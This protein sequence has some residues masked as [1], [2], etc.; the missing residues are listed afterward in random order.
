[1][2]ADTSGPLAAQYR[3]LCDTVRDYPGLLPAAEALQREL[4]RT[5]RRWYAIIE[6]LRSF[7]LKNFLLHDAHSQ[8]MEAMQTVTD[9]LFEAVEW[10]DLNVS[11]KGIDALMFYL[12]KILLDGSRSLNDYW[13]LLTSAFA[14][15]VQLDSDRFLSAVTNAHPLKR[16][17]QRILD[18]QPEGCSVDVLNSLLD[19]SFRE[20]YA[21]WLNETDPVL[22]FDNAEAFR[23]HLAALKKL[24]QPV[25]HENL[26]ALLRHLDTL[27]PDSDDISRLNALLSLP[28]H[29]QIV[30]F[31]EEHADRLPSESDGALKIAYL[32]KM[33]ESD[34]LEGIH[35]ET[36]REIGRTVSSI[37]KA[38]TPETLK[39]ALATPLEILRKNFRAFPEA[40]LHCVQSIGTGVYALGNSALV[41]WFN[42]CIIAFGFQQPE[43]SGITDDWQVS[44]NKS[45]VRNIR[46]WLELIEQSPKWSKSLLAALLIN[47]RLGGVHINDTDL[48]QKDITRLLNS[49]IAPAY[50][51][52]KQLAKGFPAY[53]NVINAEGALREVSTALDDAT[54]TRDPLV[55][56]LRK[57]CH[58]E[59][60]SIMVDFI[61][62]ALEFWRTKDKNGLRAY[63]PEEVFR[64][65]DSDGRYVTDLHRLMTELFTALQINSVSDLLLADEYAIQ[66]CIDRTSAPDRERSRAAL[67]VKFYRLLWQKYRLG[68]HD[69]REQLAASAG[70]GL[71]AC[72]ELIASLESESIQIRLAAALHHLDK[73][74]AIILSSERFEAIED[75]ARKRHVAAGI[76]SMYG[77]YI[78]KK[79]NAL[80]LT[81]RLENYANTLFEELMRTFPLR[82]VTRATLFQIEKYTKL[83]FHALK[84]DGISSHRLENTLELLSGALEVRRFSYSQFIDIFR[85][86]SEGVQDILSTY[87]TGALKAHLRAVILQLGNERIVPKYRDSGDKN[88]HDFVN[89]VSEKLLRDM[90]ALSPGLQQLD[91]FISSILRTLREQAEVLDEQKLDLLMSYDPKKIVSAIHSPARATRDRIH[92][93]N[94][95]YNLVKLSSLGIPVPPGFL[96]TT[97]VFRCM[98]AIHQFGYAKEHL[99]EEIARQLKR[100]EELTGRKLGDPQRPLLVSARSGAALSMPGMMNS[101]LNVGLN[102]AIVNGLVDMTGK[103]WFAWDCYRRFLQCWGMFFGMERDVFDTIIDTFKRRH[104]VEMKLQFTPEQMRGIALAYRDTIVQSGIAISDDPFVQLETAI[105]QVFQSWDSQKARAYRQIL[106]ISEQWGTAVLVQAMAYGNLDT[107][108]GT[109]VLFTR[110]PRELSD[111]VMLWGDFAIGAQGEDIVSG[112]VKTLPISIEQKHFEERT[113]DISLEEL[114]PEIYAA[115]QKIVKNL[116]YTEQWSAQEIEFTFEGKSAEQLAILQTRDMTVMRHESVSAFIPTQELS[117]AFCA[118][119]IGVGGG[120]LSGRAVFDLHDIQTYRKDDPLTPLILIRADTVPDD[121][122]LISATDGLLTARGGSTSHAAIIAK[123]LGKTCVVGC[124]RLSVFE[125]DKACS[126]HK[127]TVRAGDFLSIDGRGGAI[128]LGSHPSQVVRLAAE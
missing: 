106:G 55:H 16:L 85:G 64:S 116:I 88:E 123:R 112:L 98:S 21:F 115:L 114:F 7:A 13:P 87:Y 77:R 58:V 90:V 33:L 103:P 93:G 99:M 83:F 110:N 8:G 105:M 92:L 117:S 48:F 27:E 45:H 24:M 119:G 91:A 42:Q 108:S 18:R 56:F 47:L 22:W 28:G 67:I 71:P 57:H 17:A 128:Y 2:A 40:T 66:D 121:I 5:P 69:L 79:F 41:E 43:V 70:M 32:L 25:S 73:L 9:I 39:H 120:A 19:R 96:I 62:A 12:Q 122:Q 4:A 82:F 29:L 59:S 101:F 75:I 94:K 31:Y 95:G 14:R 68:I 74:K 109:G 100:I 46:V 60:S 6:D 51:L 10:P 76:P 125:A 65:I 53:F 78:E 35:E 26:R 52:V 49:D 107:N 50:H 113:Y 97:E 126:L 3:I 15:L 104:K 44:S 36:I 72:D 23:L 1:M 118:S 61:E 30:K 102:E 38:G 86:F 89:A 127:A 20:T 37:L 111:R 54:G 81:F 80:A 124:P 34:G 84:L 11:R 63:L